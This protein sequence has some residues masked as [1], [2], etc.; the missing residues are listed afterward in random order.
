VKN[1]L[2]DAEDIRKAVDI[3]K[4]KLMQETFNKQ[5]ELIEKARAESRQILDEACAEK[6]R[7]IDSLEGELTDTL[8]SLLNYLIGEEIYN[9][10]NWLSCIVRRMLANDALK[11]NI[12]VL[13][14]PVL[15]SKLADEEIERLTHIRDDV[16]IQVSDAISD[17]EC[18][19]ESNEGSI[20]YDV[21][22]G[23]ERV[24]SDI[25]ILQNLKQ[26]TL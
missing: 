5:E 6:Q 19:I 25:K 13:V 8:K 21:Q 3:E 7:M 24:I 12:K 16:T 14:S 9:N 17:T 26:V 1:A 18:R 10:T 15:Y 4:S 23:L 20:Q 11:N 2:K 22:E